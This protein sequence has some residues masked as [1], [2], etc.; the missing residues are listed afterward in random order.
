MRVFIVHAL[1]WKKTLMDYNKFFFYC[2]LRS[3]LLR[4]RVDQ[5]SDDLKTFPS[6]E[7]CAVFDELDVLNHI[8]IFCACALTPT[9]MTKSLMIMSVPWELKTIDLLFH[10]YT[11]VNLRTT[12]RSIVLCCEVFCS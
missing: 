4:F 7:K 3:F 6:V 9:W 10:C 8:Y 11:F 2:A 12:C 5:F 1:K